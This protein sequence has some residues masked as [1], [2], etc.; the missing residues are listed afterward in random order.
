MHQQLV[1][2]R[3]GFQSCTL[4]KTPNQIPKRIYSTLFIPVPQPIV[5]WPT[6]V[7]L[8]PLAFV[9]SADPIAPEAVVSRVA[10]IGRSR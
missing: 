7:A 4:R 1:R 6:A 8:K 9:D 10:L 2:P 5:P 3:L